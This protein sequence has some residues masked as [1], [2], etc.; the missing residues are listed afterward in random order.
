MK[1]PC[2]NALCAGLLALCTTAPAAAC[3]M[4]SATP[5]IEQW[6]DA[7][8]LV[9]GEVLR[10]PPAKAP[11][12]V[13]FDAHCVWTTSAAS[14]VNAP[15]VEGPSLLGETL[16]WRVREHGG[17]L[18]LPDGGKAPPG[19]MSFAAPDGHGGE[20]F[21][22]PSP[23]FWKEAGVESAEFGLAKLLVAVFVHE[24][25]HTRQIAGFQQVIAPLERQW[26]GE[27]ELS[28]DTVQQMFGDRP[29][30][31]M[32][33]AA[34]RD[35]LF[36]AATAT[37]NEAAREQATSALVAM[38]SRHAA[39]FT[40]DHAWFAPLD[41]AFLSFE[42]AGQWVAYRWLHHPAGGGFDAALALSGLRRGGRFWSQ[43]EGLALFLVLDRL[44]PAWPERA[45]GHP[46]AG[47][48]ELLGNAL[49]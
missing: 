3:N 16:S 42:G 31:A 15:V 33:F 2:R 49:H 39:Y 1:N 20:F 22:M 10:L 14:G 29:G 6:F 28:D 12:M 44:D 30:Y 32:A 25:S 4:A 35:L 17:E 48:L 19:L 23:A 13:F 40:G 27:Q 26:K 38:Q 45:Y 43:D 41:D 7:W 9:V 34:E 5:W 8:E 47:A 36:A 24:F 37:S 46:A 21:V 11:A 18:L